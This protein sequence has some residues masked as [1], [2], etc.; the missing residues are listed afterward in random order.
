MI[1]VAAGLL[2]LLQG[3]AP[4]TQLGFVVEPDTVTVGDPFRLVVRVRA[5]KGATVEFPTAMDSGGMVEALDPVVVMPS[6]DPSLTDQT[7]TYRLAA[8]DVGRLPLKLAD[9][10]VRLNGDERALALRDLF[11]TVRSVL[12][13]DSS[14]RV[15]RPP[16]DVMAI[17]PPWWWW[18]AL[19]AVVAVL[20]LL[21]WSWW[22]RR[23]RVRPAPVIDPLREA[24]AAFE[25]IDRL[26]L[27][28]AGERARHAALVIEVLRDYLG[29]VVPAASTSLT[30]AELLAAIRDEPRVAANRL[31]A[32]LIEVD[33]VKFA[34]RPLAPDRAQTIGTETKALVHAIDA[35]MH[36]SG[37]QEAA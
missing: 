31:A 14:Q 12:P 27:V 1:A 26:G 34:R 10:I 3:T 22:R 5:P 9:V 8:W 32:L 7:A 21:L 18:A 37:V 11:V 24:D 20:L 23:R 4:R 19:A 16:R 35:A 25:R 6:S 29:R 15:P 33:L 13:A 17:P 28:V 36:A 30:T 2:F